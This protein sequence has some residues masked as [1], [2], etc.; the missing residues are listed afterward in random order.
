[1]LTCTS[2]EWSSEYDSYEPIISS[3]G[4]LRFINLSQ[5]G[6]GILV[7]WDVQTINDV[8]ITLTRKVSDLKELVYAFDREQLRYI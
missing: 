5:A 6:A 4:V 1:M 3:T 7:E 8:L 2:E